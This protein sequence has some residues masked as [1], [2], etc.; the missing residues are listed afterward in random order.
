MICNEVAVVIAAGQPFEELPQGAPNKHIM[1][2]LERECDIILC[3]VQP[4]PFGA[5]WY[6]AFPAP[7]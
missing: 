3:G 5:C 7:G 1:S 4:C 2:T 6:E